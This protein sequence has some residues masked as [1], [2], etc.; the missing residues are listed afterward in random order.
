M[1]SIAGFE[2]EVLLEIPGVLFLRVTDTEYNLV[3]EIEMFG[4]YSW[5]GEL[6]SGDNSYLTEDYMKALIVLVTEALYEDI[7]SPG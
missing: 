1:F 6:I 5:V 2:I 3:F 4:P 7:S